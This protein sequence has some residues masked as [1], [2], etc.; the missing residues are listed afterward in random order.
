MHR[1]Q[2][3]EREATF[4]WESDHIKPKS[5]NGSDGLFNRQPLHCKTNL[6]KGDK[7]PWPLSAFTAP[8]W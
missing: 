5:L 2:Y 4:G 6:E 3:G 1:P 7:Y 8:L